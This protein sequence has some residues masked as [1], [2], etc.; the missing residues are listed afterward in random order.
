L[1]QILLD[2]EHARAL[3]LSLYGKVPPGATAVEVYQ[4]TSDLRSECSSSFA[5]GCYKPDGLGGGKI[6]LSKQVIAGSHM[7]RSGAVH[8]YTHLVQNL[9]GYSHAPSWVVEGV[10][11]YFERIEFK[12]GAIHVGYTHPDWAKAAL[13]TWV[14]VDRLVSLSTHDLGEARVSSFYF[15]SYLLIHVLRHSPDYSSKLPEFLKLV[16]EGTVRSADAFLD[17][18]GVTC[19]ELDSQLRNYFQRGKFQQFAAYPG[20]KYPN[21]I[22]VADASGRKVKVKKKKCYSCT[23]RK[24]GEVLR[25]VSIFIPVP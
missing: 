18:Y 1:G 7:E 11:G 19:S 23:A 25:H 8:E 3:F 9:M 24:V 4:N 13:Q 17:V 21:E 20:I 10:A 6:L 16:K 12:D 5:L 15:L 22:R 14:P 2:L